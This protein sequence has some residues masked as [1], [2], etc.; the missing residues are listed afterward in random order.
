MSSLIFFVCGVLV[1]N[2]FGMF[3][4]A[5][6]TISGIPDNILEL[7]KGEQCGRSKGSL[8]LLRQQ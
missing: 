5:L 2:L 4:M 7:D 6:V 3:I 1:G 8:W